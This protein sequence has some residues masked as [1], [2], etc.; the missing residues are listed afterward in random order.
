[1]PAMAL[2]ASA[3]SSASTRSLAA[4]SMVRENST[5]MAL[6]PLGKRRGGE[7][8]A[9]MACVFAQTLVLVTPLTRCVH[10]ARCR[11]SNPSLLQLL[12]ACFLDAPDP[13]RDQDPFPRDHR[14]HHHGPPEEGAAE[15]LD[16]RGAPAETG[17]AAAGRACLHA[18]FRAGA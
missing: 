12:G 16:A 14:H 6:S 9:A 1:M 13:R 8:C 17:A 15:R 4:S 2:V 10:L 7:S 5:A 18:A 11:P 3:R